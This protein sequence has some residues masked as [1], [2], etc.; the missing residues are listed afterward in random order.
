MAAA[1]MNQSTPEASAAAAVLAASGGYSSGGR[2]YYNGNSSDGSSPD[3]YS[4]GSGVRN[5]R[6]ILGDRTRICS[7]DNMLV[8]FIYIQ[9]CQ[10]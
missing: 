1:M 2:S 6:P 9:I 4:V 5:R 8:F 7:L 10:W 3:N